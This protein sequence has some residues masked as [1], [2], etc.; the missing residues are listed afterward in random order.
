MRIGTREV[1]LTKDSDV[2]DLRSA[3]GSYRAIR[4]N[5]P[6]GNL[7][8]SNIQ[9]RYSNGRAHDERRN[10]NLFEGERTR[11]I[12]QRDEERFVEGVT[13]CYKADAKASKKA[14][15]EVYGLQTTKGGSAARPAI[16]SAL[17]WPAACPG[18]APITVAAPAPAAK[19]PHAPRV[20]S[21]RR[22][23][24]RRR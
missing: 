21:P 7:A 15:V 17:T 6:S 13:L 20:R 24:C 9:V 8:L 1:D 23:L 19:G 22:R 14:V 2:I 12:D 10:I 11:P 3:K 4:V 18:G 16:T 5:L